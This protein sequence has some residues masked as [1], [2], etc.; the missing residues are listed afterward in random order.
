VRTLAGHKMMQGRRGGGKFRGGNRINQSGDRF[1]DG[2]DANFLAGSRSSC[3]LFSDHDNRQNNNNNNNFKTNRRVSFKTSH[4]H[5]RNLNDVKV[6]A[7]L[8]DED[9][10]MGG[11]V[12]GDMGPNVSGD[13]RRGG[14]FRNMRKGM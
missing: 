10:H 3:A 7:F 6:K 9:M 14:K 12:G 8:D 2:N 1:Q 4:R 11:G 13:R 5:N